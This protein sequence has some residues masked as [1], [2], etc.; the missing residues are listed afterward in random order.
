MES[1]EFCLTGCNESPEQIVRESEVVK[2]SKEEVRDNESS[3][4]G[5]WWCER[6]KLKILKLKMVFGPCS[7]PYYSKSFEP[8]C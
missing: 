5:E 6:E 1:S 7:W 4:G 8:G 3:L 2:W